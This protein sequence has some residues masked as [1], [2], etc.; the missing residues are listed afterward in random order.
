MSCEE[1]PR[2]FV[3]E[4]SESDAV[5]P[6]P[7]SR[8]PLKLVWEFSDS[9]Y[10]LTKIP[11]YQSAPA[12]INTDVSDYPR[13]VDLEYAAEMQHRRYVRE[14][15]ILYFKICEK[16][17]QVKQFIDTCVIRQMMKSPLSVS[18]VCCSCATRVTE[19]LPFDKRQF[20]DLEQDVSCFRDRTLTQKYQCGHNCY[21]RCD[22]CFWKTIGRVSFASCYACARDD[23]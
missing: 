10:T 18:M 16:M 8:R 11:R 14:L 9:I 5:P 12:L 15:V 17:P 2:I 23:E 7:G 1:Q 20:L 13:V 22:A 19:K 6:P 3:A 21:Y 4:T